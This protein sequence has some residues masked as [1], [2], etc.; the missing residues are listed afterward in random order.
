MIIEYESIADASF[1]CYFVKSGTVFSE[2]QLY[3]IKA[4]PHFHRNIE[5]LFITRGTQRVNVDGEFLNINEG[6]ILFVDSY[7]PHSYDDCDAEAYILVLSSTY[8]EPFHWFYDKKVFPQIMTDKEKNKDVFAFVQN[9][10][11]QHIKD[12]EH[13]E[14]FI[15]CN[16]LFHLITQ[17]YEIKEPVISKQNELVI[18]ALKYIKDHYCE[19]DLTLKSCSDAIGYS[20]EYVSKQFNN[21]MGTSFKGYVNS[22]RIQKF[23]ELEQT[24]KGTKQELAV[25]CGFKSVAT[26]YRALKNI[27]E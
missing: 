26:F 27:D 2:T 7:Q 17:K 13:Y 18:A 8:F 16:E 21:V 11:E 23:Q 4:T 12:T 1:Y 9:W 24:K 20:K 25:M 6:E 15:K 14:I 10:Y 22:L 3:T 5:F 19:D